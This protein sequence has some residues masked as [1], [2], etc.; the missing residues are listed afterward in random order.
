[1]FTESRDALMTL[2]TAAQTAVEGLT[3]QHKHRTHQPPATAAAH[4]TL[5]GFYTYHHKREELPEVR[6]SHGLP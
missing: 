2:L 1:M 4:Y 6:S 5:A 3:A